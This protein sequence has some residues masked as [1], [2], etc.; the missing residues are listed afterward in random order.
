MK[1]SGDR[2]AIGS[3]ASLMFSVFV[4]AFRAVF[5]YW[6]LGGRDGGSP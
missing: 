2:V 4:T 6:V 3:R 5:S 1:G